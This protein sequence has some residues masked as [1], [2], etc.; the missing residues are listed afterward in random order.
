MFGLSQAATRIV[1]IGAIIVLLCFALAV[2][3]MC[4]KPSARNEER[5]ATSVGTQLDKVA[6]KTPVIR[7]EQEEKQREVDQIEGADTPLPDGF[8]AELE[9]VRRGR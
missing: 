5:V 4:R 6:A 2:F 3:T 7:Q 9:R 8:S 1:T